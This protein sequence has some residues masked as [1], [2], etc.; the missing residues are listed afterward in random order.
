VDR[1]VFATL[2]PDQ[3]PTLWW[4]I[5]FT[6]TVISYLLIGTVLSDSHPKSRWIPHSKLIP[7]DWADHCFLSYNLLTSA[8]WM[9]EVALP[10]LA[11]GLEQGLA[12]WEK[13]VELL[14]GAYFTIDSIVAIVQWKRGSDF[15][16]DIV[17]QVAINA[18]AYTYMTVT[19]SRTA[20]KA[21]RR[22]DEGF[23]PLTAELPAVAPGVTTTTTTVA[24]GSRP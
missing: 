1:A 18:A 8:L 3:N 7:S 15:T 23:H 17:P 22:R 4:L 20:W 16:W 13:K 2:T 10:S 21:W 9:I 19:V 6:T 11:W 5:N 24:A 14:L 12:G